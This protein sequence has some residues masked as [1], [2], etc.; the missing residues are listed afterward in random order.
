MGK[1]TRPLF[2][3]VGVRTTNHAEIRVAQDLEA[4][5]WRLIKRGWPDFLAVKGDK[6]RFIE[7]KPGDSSNLSHF[8]QEIANLLFR[9]YGIEVESIA[10]EGPPH[11]K[12]EYRNIPSVQEYLARHRS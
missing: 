7:V 11:V 1:E 5:G 6:I 3:P 9:H 4:D 10:P 2:V 8:Q 12:P